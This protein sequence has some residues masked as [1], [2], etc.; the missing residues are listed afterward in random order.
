[1]T[2]S[3]KIFNNYWEDE[4]TGE[5]IPGSFCFVQ[6]GYVRKFVSGRETA[7]CLT[8]SNSHPVSVHS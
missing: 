4:R 8:P 3:S 5:S 2:F 1:M 6:D 7:L